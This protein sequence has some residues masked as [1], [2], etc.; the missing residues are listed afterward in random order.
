VSD[1]RPGTVYL[2]GAGPGDPELI[3][4]RGLR[5][6]SAADVVLYDAL[7]HPDLL[8]HARPD[9][10]VEFVGKRAGRPSARQEAINAR[11]VAEARAGRSVVRLKGGDPFLFGRGSEEAEALV[12]AGVPFEVVPGVASPM[13]VCAYAGISLTHRALSSSV[14]FLTASEHPEKD[15]S[16]HD[17]A[18]LA[19]ATETLV[20]FMG[21]RQ[22]EHTM[23]RLRAH[24]RSPEEPAAIFEW[25]SLPRQRSVVGTIGTLPGLARE[26]GI[27]LP[28]LTVVGRVVTLRETIAW[29]DRK[30]LFGWR[31]LVT[32]PRGQEHGLSR[33]LRDAG[34]EPIAI[35][36]I[37]I[38]PP[39]DPGP[40]RRAAHQ[41][42]DYDAVVFT[43]ANGVGAFFGALAETGGDARRLGRARVAAIGP[44]TAEALADR[45]VRADVV[46][47]E[48][49]GEAAAAA[50]LADLGD[51]AR[52]ARVLLPRA[53]VA[54]EVLPE[55][56]RGAGARVDV[57]P[58]Y[59]TLGPDAA[60]AERLRSLLAAREVDAVTLTSSST[61]ERL[62]EALGG[63]GPAAAALDGVTLASIGPITTATAERL[64]LRVAVSAAEYTAPGLLAA[65]E[66]HAARARDPGPARAGGTRSGGPAA[67]GAAAG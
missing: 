9:A 47:A 21:V 4:E 62:C 29:F 3:T 2:V 58:A 8:A 5:R 41:A 44:A 46:P 53:L 20:I 56:L 19:R 42:G 51:R 37:R 60:D 30:P 65:L 22:L 48:F 57:V 61:A 33:A 11:L 26:A 40:L 18:R 55:V 52:G 49:R 32:R 17:W 54:R 7:V 25:A 23:A 28:A 43:S 24:G 67:G 12:A 36:T 63:P 13:A 45:G 38:A 59:R 50:I 1:A 35:P 34:A 64:G 27:G 10:T 31:V 16:A 15:E 14:A 66:A 39:E 6:L